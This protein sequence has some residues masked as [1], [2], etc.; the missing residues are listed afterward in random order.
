MLQLYITF[1]PLSWLIPVIATF[2]SSFFFFNDCLS[3]F[4][5]ITMVAC[6]FVFCLL[7]VVALFF[8]FFFFPFLNDRT[9]ISIDKRIII[10][11]NPQGKSKKWKK[12]MHNNNN[13]NNNTINNTITLNVENFD[14]INRYR[15][16]GIMISV[17][18]DFCFAQPHPLG[19]VV[20][21]AE[22]PNQK[23]W[24]FWKTLVQ[25]ERKTSHCACFE[26]YYSAPR[27]SR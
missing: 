2:N 25:Y 17:R 3:C 24:T 11:H 10:I 26:C 1:P 18:Q 21:A 8:I 27:C 12:K 19:V 22:E 4:F 5:V 7:S 9:N 20:A 23:N 13:I 16:I 6:M 15:E 14:N